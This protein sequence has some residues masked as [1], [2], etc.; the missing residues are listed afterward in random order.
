MI[1]DN[2][3]AKEKLQCFNECNKV[4][5][6]LFW[7]LGSGFCRLRSNEGT[8]PEETHGGAWGPYYG[9][10]KYCAVNGEFGSC[11][12]WSSSL[13]VMFNKLYISFF[14]ILNCLQTTLFHIS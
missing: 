11:I 2:A 10:P 14:D 9:G 3:P 5:E 1:N 12:F 8:G 13:L 4:Q 7:D 6:C